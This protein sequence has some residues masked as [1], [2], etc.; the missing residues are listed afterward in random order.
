MPDAT[1]PSAAQVAAELK[2]LI[3]AERAGEPFLRVR[4]GDG[5]QRIFGLPVGSERATIGRHSDC[6]VSLAWDPEVSRLHALVERVGTEWTFI[7]DGLSS[8]GSFINGTRVVGRHRLKDGDRLCCGETV[9]V[10][11]DPVARDLASTERG[12]S[13][14]DSTTFT[15]TQRNVL[16]ALC[17][18]ISNSASATPATNRQ[19]A[20]EVFL[21]V[22][23]VKAHLRVLFERFGLN[24]LPQNEKRARLAATVIASG[25][26]LPRDF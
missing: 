22:D 23:A 5:C 17:R 18:P 19:I 13:P 4:A 11:R 21:S 2:A 1:P 26:L 24:E 7:D 9:L 6:D 16:V 8:N 10:Y 15:P 25:V 12:S 3:A 20:E 14:P